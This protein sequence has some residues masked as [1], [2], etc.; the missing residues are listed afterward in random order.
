MRDFLAGC[1]FVAVSFV[2]CL[3]CGAAILGGGAILVVILA[4]LAVIAAVWILIVCIAAR[5]S[6]G[7]ANITF[8]VGKKA[9]HVEA[10]H[11]TQGND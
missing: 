4:P 9:K 7:R 11:E 3:V 8:N 2:A 6:G 10:E 5:I 1:L